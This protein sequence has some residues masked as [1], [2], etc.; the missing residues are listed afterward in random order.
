MRVVEGGKGSRRV[1]SIGKPVLE[2]ALHHVVVV[3]PRVGAHHL[4]VRFMMTVVMRMMTIV[5]M[6]AMMAM[7]TM[8]MTMMTMATMMMMTM[9]M[10]MMLLPLPP[11]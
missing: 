8:M 3:Q 7:M 5:A 9:T 4:D 2:S 6:M 11:H 10:A 1:S